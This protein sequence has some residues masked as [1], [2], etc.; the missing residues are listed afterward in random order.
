[1]RPLPLLPEPA[2]VP[3]REEIRKF[4]DENPPQSVF[5]IPPI[6][7]DAFEN[8]FGGDRLFSVHDGLYCLSSNLPPSISEISYGRGDRLQFTVG[9][10][11]SKSRS[12]IVVPAISVDDL[13]LE[14][15]SIVELRSSLTARGY[16]EL[17]TS[18]GGSSYSVTFGKE[19]PP[20]L[21]ASEL[22]DFIGD[23]EGA[24]PDDD[25]EEYSIDL[26]R[27]QPEPGQRFTAER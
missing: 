1:M 24:R 26:D 21:V 6:V 22:Q 7:H 11:I 18:S 10:Q 27:P 5:A 14:V 2:R 3:S 9:F 17:S 15:R 25:E 19:V 16:R 20:E 23:L 4:L 12:G 13:E 8:Q